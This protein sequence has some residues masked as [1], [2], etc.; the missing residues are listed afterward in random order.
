VARL[1]KEKH[2]IEIQLD[3]VA[4]DD[5]GIAADTLVTAQHKGVTP[6]AALEEVPGDLELT[7]VIAD[8]VLLITT[9]EAARE[10]C[11]TAAYPLGAAAG[12]W[13]TGGAK[14]APDDKLVRKIMA[15][16]AQESWQK[17]G[18]G[19]AIGV[20]SPGGKI[21]LAVRQTYPV[22]EQIAELLGTPGIREEDRTVLFRQPP[23]QPPAPPRRKAAESTRGGRYL[24]VGLRLPRSWRYTWDADSEEIHES[25]R[26]QR[27]EAVRGAEAGGDARSG[28]TVA[29]AA[30]D[31][32]VG[33]RAAARAPQFAG[34]RTGRATRTLGPH[35]G[36]R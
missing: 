1:L 17:E 11:Y 29:V 28:R 24:S 26:R 6:R 12:A 22:H 23:P 32:Y 7:F 27:I 25:D 8:E 21:V 2:E 14:N 15:S 16:V 35:G 13:L 34:R 31:D 4:L 33:R 3:K 30:R 5:E 9:P 20:L 19:C 18:G 10:R 36:T